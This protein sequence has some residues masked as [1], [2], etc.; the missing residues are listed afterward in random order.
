MKPDLH[1]LGIAFTQNKEQGGEDD[2]GEED[3]ELFRAEAECVGV[4]VD[5]LVLVEI[6]RDDGRRVVEEVGEHG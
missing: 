2:R 5:E 3:H 1:G 6:R 4:G